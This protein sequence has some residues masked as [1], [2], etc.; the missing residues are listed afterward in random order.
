MEWIHVVVVSDAVNL[1]AGFEQASRET[2]L[3][4]VDRVSDWD[5]VAGSFDRHR[6]EVMVV[7][8]A[9]WRRCSGRRLNRLPAQQPVVHV[10]MYCESMEIDVISEAVA[11]GVQGVLP[12]V[13]SAS[14]WARA[15]EVLLS[16]DIAM[17]R[18]WL[19][20]ALEKALHPR[21]E[22][23]PGFEES[24]PLTERESDVLRCVTGG[25]SNKEI[26]RHLGIAEA[27]VKTHLHHVFAK[28]RI[29]RRALLMVGGTGIVQ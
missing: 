13:A 26:A 3:R 7:D 18:A 11:Y 16:G 12:E 29:G 4:V 19:A 6:P 28:L 9:F 10:L 25:M 14:Q 17:P 1:P 21:A 27:T 15:I 22:A 23:A 2:G 8:R 24:E 5:E 20:R